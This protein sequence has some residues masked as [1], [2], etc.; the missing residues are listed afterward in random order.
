[1]L[2]GFI[3]GFTTSTLIFSCFGSSTEKRSIAVPMKRFE[4]QA[5]NIEESYERAIGNLQYQ[6][7]ELQMNLNETKDLLDQVK[8]SLKKKEVKLK[9]LLEPKSFSAN[10]LRVQLQKVS[11]E[12]NVAACDSLVSGVR[13]Y[14]IDNGRKDSI[15]DVQ[16]AQLENIVL[17]K[18][19]VINLQVKEKEDFKILINQSLIEQQELAKVNKQLQKKNRR[20]R[21]KTKLFSVGSVI[22]TALVS[23]YVFG[24]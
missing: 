14:L 22:V 6:N 3:L 13:Q 9:K 18:D 16:Q 5:V 19:S 21:F 4:K 24:H 2:I 12:D 8:L 17:I 23:S 20:G 15:Y 11:F 1:M 10:P 7:F